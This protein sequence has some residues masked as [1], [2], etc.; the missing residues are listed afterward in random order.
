MLPTKQ[1][2]L[3]PLSAGFIWK[4]CLYKRESRLTSARRTRLYSANSS[5][6]QNWNV[7]K[8]GICIRISPG[9]M[10]LYGR[11]SSQ[12]ACKTLPAEAVLF[13]FISSSIHRNLCQT[14]LRCQLICCVWPQVLR[15]QG[16]C[17]GTGRRKT[18]F[19]FRHRILETS[20]SPDLPGN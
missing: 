9:Y 1:G 14:S 15:C 16:F 8:V 5:P 7:L 12:V 11:L 3:C 20:H 13:C 18:L 6:F 4:M 17:L 2:I 10:A 19:C